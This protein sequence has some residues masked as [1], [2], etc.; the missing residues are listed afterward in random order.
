MD[1]DKS[2][3]IGF[4]AR[5]HGLK[6]EVTMMLGP[7]CPDLG[8]VKSLFVEVGGQL[9]PFFVESVSVRGTKAFLKL[10]DVNTPEK[11]DALKG[12]S[13]YLPKTERPR[14][15]RGDFYSDEVIGFEVTDA[16]AGV[17]GNVTDVLENGPTRY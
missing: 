12:S 5:S 7:E 1:K 10:E 13:L 16:E 3:K 14:L 6:G 11:A 15:D 4:V 8:S 17:L 9:V 2:F